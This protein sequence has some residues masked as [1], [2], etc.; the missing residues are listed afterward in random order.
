MR[1]RII[2][3]AAVVVLVIAA[4]VFSLDYKNQREEQALLTGQT[5]DANRLLSL[6]PRPPQDLEQRLAE[7]EKS[8][9]TEM[10]AFPSGIDSTKL[11]NYILE[12][13]DG[14]GIKAIPLL[15]Q[16]L[17]VEKVGKREY[18]VFRLNIAVEGSFARLTDFVTELESG[19][20]KTLILEELTVSIDSAQAIQGQIVATESFPV[21]ADINLAFYAQHS[22]ENTIGGEV[23]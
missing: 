18:Y 1:P 14:L 2:V 16:P 8:L 5:A 3:I 7:A 12:L 19:V 15:T 21:T 10:E 9:A 11:I 6:L 17:A 20:Y 4:V 13:A 22:Q 23:P